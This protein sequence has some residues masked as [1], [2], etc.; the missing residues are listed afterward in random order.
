MGLELR[1]LRSVHHI[2]GAAGRTL[3]QENVGMSKKSLVI[4]CD[5]CQEEEPDGGSWIERNDLTAR[6]CP[7]APHQN[8]RWVQSAAVKWYVQLLAL[9]RWANST[10]HLK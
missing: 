6:H 2:E 10:A 7:S 5:C 4:A 1:L 3:R 8:L 9:G